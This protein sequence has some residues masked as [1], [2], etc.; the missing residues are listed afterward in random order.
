MVLRNFRSSSQY[1]LHR[2]IS[3][4]VGTTTL[5]KLK[6]VAVNKLIVVCFFFRPKIPF[7]LLKRYGGNEKNLKLRK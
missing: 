7:S 3:T 4:K 6:N 5:E 1:I 2:Y